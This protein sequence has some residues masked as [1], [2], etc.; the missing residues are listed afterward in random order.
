MA[1]I[2]H[3][4]IYGNDVASVGVFH[5]RSFTDS[6]TPGNIVAVRF[7]ATGVTDFVDDW[8]LGLKVNGSSVL[9][10]SDRIHITAAD[11]SPENT[12]VSIPVSLQ[13]RFQPEVLERGGGVL[14]GPIVIIVDVDD[15]GAGT[16]A[17]I[18]G[19]VNKATP[20][21]AD[22]FGFWDSVAALFKYVTWA[23]IKTTLKAYFDTLYATPADVAAA[24]AGLAWKN[25]VR[26]ATTANITLSG[27][28]TI[29]GVSVIAGDR[30]LVKNQ[31]TGSQNGI[32]V[33]ASGS[34]VRATDNDTA[35]EMLQASCYVE[36][37]TANADKQFVCTTNAPI[38]LGSTSLTF[39]EF[40]SSSVHNLP[41]LADV[42]N[43]TAPTA[44]AMLV[45]T[46]SEWNADYQAG[47]NQAKILLDDAANQ[48]VLGDVDSLGN[49]MVVVVDD[50][51][52]EV[53]ISDRIKFEKTVGNEGK[54]K[55]G[56]TSLDFD[57]SGIDKNRSLLQVA[58]VSPWSG[59][60]GFGY[61]GI[62]S[63]I[64]RT[65]N[66]GVNQ[67]S[68]IRGRANYSGSSPDGPVVTGGEFFSSND[69][70][71][72][73][74]ISI[75][76]V[77]G[78]GSAEDDAA[79]VQG[80]GA[81]ANVNGTSTVSDFAAGVFGNA[82][83]A[84]GATVAKLCGLFY[85]LFPGG[86]V[87]EASG[88]WVRVRRITAGTVT[89]LF[90][91][92]IGDWDG[93]TTGV[94]NSYGIFIDNTIDVG[95]TLKYAI[96]SESTSQSQLAGPL[97][98]IAPT[99][100]LHAAT[101]KYVD[102]T[103]A[104]SG[105]YTDEQAQDAVGGILDNGTVGDLSF[106]YDD[107]TPK[108]SAVVKNAAISLAKMASMA[109][110]S[111][112]GRTTAG[113]GAPEI[114]SVSQV[115]SMLG[116]AD[117]MIFKGVTDC[118]AN[119]NYPAGDAGDFY[120][121]S[122]DGKIGGASGISVKAG[123]SFYC[124]TDGTASG[125]QATVGANWVIVFSALGDTVTE[126]EIV[127]SDNTTND[128]STS[129]HGFLKKLDNDT[130]HFMRGD[131]AWA[132]PG[133]GGISRS[134]NT[135]SGNFTAGSTASTDYVYLIAANHTPTLPTA[136]G[137]TNVYVFK[138]NHTVR[139]TFSTTSS[140]TIDG[141]S[142]FKIYPGEQIVFFSD[143]ANWV[144]DARNKWRKI[145][146]LSTE[147]RTSNTTTSNDADLQFEM[148][149]NKNYNIRIKA[150][151]F[152]NGAS[153]N[154]KYT[155]VGPTS[156]GSV[157]LHRTHGAGVATVPTEGIEVGF[158]FTAVSMTVSGAGASGLGIVEIEGVVRNGSNAGTFAFQFAQG[159]SSA[160]AAQ[161]IDGSTIEYLEN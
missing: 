72:H 126:G 132:V 19:A 60:L 21:D 114:L 54:L 154:F 29:D 109:T 78:I 161:V 71:T 7:K 119:P 138:N 94:T 118:S 152:V 100:D 18:S 45:G 139:I 87:A 8:Y 120:K 137:N 28:Q 149:A 59:D 48:V 67:T 9:L 123:D 40:A 92:K 130:T 141:L 98:I 50:D 113:T 128:A 36:E 160:T 43:A 156:P 96:K 33:A 2:R 11:L 77:E 110:A 124:I 32:Y 133:G 46:G 159:T 15:L 69:G 13:D 157:H 158:N 53:K 73:A 3:E 127:L 4:F 17:E 76:G 70:A 117:A 131:G 5:S 63:N 89:N 143:G 42:N 153:I 146:K 108:I 151:T 91:L 6:L 107:S 14:N 83:S 47:N 64:V 56:D 82:V 25:P 31:S 66:V 52:Q 34:W 80:C 79:N 129:N 122:V 16:A 84:V 105:G 30:V 135:T 115:R 61:F 27:A 22:R 38:T 101:K 39:V 74:S 147:S 140:Q 51:N 75:Q 102:D 134:I 116:I 150:Y 35:I 112:I 111:F 103:V 37:G 57:A 1:I 99:A 142:T 49:D 121:V 95:G 41:D 104:A 44:G 125:N 81:F 106:T 12:T 65:G 68:A 90:G 88:I 62:F 145:I 144:T 86:T 97:T 26:A 58:D 24:V 136:V 55:I 20:V 93:A 23:Q 85:Q 148:V 155:V 10:G